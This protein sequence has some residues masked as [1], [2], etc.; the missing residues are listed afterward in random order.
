M[1]KILIG[2]GCLLVLFFCVFKIYDTGKEV[3]VS[4]TTEAWEKQKKEEREF[5][6]ELQKKYDSLQ[7]VNKEL[8]QRNANELLKAQEEYANALSSFIADYDKRLL[9]SENRAS[10]Y[11][12]QAQ[13]GASERARL[14][15]YAAELD[16]SLEEGRHLVR[17]LTTTVRQREIEIKTLSKQIQLDRNLFE[18]SGPNGK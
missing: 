10:V 3:G 6:Q 4:L 5:S 17:Q 1:N 12:R 9:S 16:R 18:M 2:V 7:S 11:K 13:G 15:S 14:A 8:S